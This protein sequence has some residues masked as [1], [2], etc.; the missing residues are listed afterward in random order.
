VT[1]ALGIHKLLGGLTFGLAPMNLIAT[2]PLFF[3]INKK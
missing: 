3:F 2:L 1:R